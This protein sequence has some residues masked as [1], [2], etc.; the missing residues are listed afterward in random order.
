MDKKE[1]AIFSQAPK[2]PFDS[3]WQ[4]VYFKNIDTI[5]M[6]CQ[7]S[8]YQM[9]WNQADQYWPDKKEALNF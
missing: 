3:F 4:A 5:V 8:D 2:K 9:H 1:F 7:L 6:L